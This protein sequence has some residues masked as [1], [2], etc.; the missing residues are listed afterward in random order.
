MRCAFILC[1][2]VA[3]V[4][5]YHDAAFSPYQEYTYE[6][7]SRTLTGFPEQKDQYSGVFSRA[8]LTL[9]QKSETE[10][11]GRLT[12]AEYAPFNGQLI[13]GWAS[14]VDE[15]TL[16]YKQQPF[17]E[18]P[19]AIEYKNGVIR[20]LAFDPCM[21]N[22]HVNQVKGVVSQFQLDLAGENEIKCKYNQMPEYDAHKSIV[23]AYKTMEATV[24]GKC[25]VQYRVSPVP[26]QFA[27][28][29]REWFPIPELKQNH[30]DQHVQIVKTKNFERCDKRIGYHFSLQTMEEN[31]DKPNANQMGDF[32]TR[33]SVSTIYI[34]GQ[35]TNYT[36]QSAATYNKVLVNNNL[37]DDE[38]PMVASY[39]KVTLQDVKPLHGACQGPDNA[40]PV[41]DLV[42]RYNLPS[43]TTNAIRPV[44]E[45]DDD[46]DSSSSSDDSDSSSS[47]SSDDDSSETNQHAKKTQLLREQDKLRER[48]Q[49]RKQQQQ[50]D[51]Q[52]YNKENN[53]DKYQPKYNER[54]PEPTEQ[55]FRRARRSVAGHPHHEQDH[56]YSHKMEEVNYNNKKNADDSDDD[57]SSDDSN[58]SDNSSSSSSSSDDSSSS[59][60]DEDSS[61]SESY[62][63]DSSSSESDSLSESQEFWHPKPNMKQSPEHAYLPFFV[64]YK[65]HSIAAKIDVAKKCIEICQ[66]IAKDAQEPSQLPKHNTLAKFTLAVRLIRIMDFEQIDFVAQK[67]HLAHQNALHQTA[68]DK[69]NQ[70]SLP[71]QHPA[72]D[73]WYAFR[74]ACAEAG[75]GPAVA[76]IFEWV[77]KKVVTHEEAAQLVATLPN[78]VQAPTDKLLHDFFKM[79]TSTYV[80]QQEVLNVTALFALTKIVEQAVVNNQTSY[81]YY[82]VNVYGRLADK[83]SP[84]VHDIAQWLGIQLKYAIVHE[85]SHQV[86][87]YI[88]CLGN[89]G[90]PDILSVFE[91][92]LEGE[93]PCTDFQRTAIVV[94][95]DRLTQNY[96]RL[97]GSVLYKLY[98]N[99]GEAHEVRC[100]AVMQLMRTEPPVHIL[101]AMAEFTHH[102]PSRE[103]RACVKA[104]IESAAELEHAHYQEF[105]AAARAAEPMLTEEEFG[106]SYSAVYLKD[107]ILEKFNLAAL[108]QFTTLGSSDSIYPSGIHAFVEKSFRGYRRETLVYA[109]ASS[110]ERLFDLFD[111]QFEEKEYNTDKYPKDHD[112][113]HYRAQK[114]SA[115]SKKNSY[116]ASGGNPKSTGFADWTFDKVADMLNIQP[117]Q[118][119]PVEAQFLFNLLGSER[120]Y[121]FGNATIEQHLPE[122]IREF[123]GVAKQGY[124]FHYS[125]IYNQDQLTIAFPM[126]SGLIFYHHYYVPTYFSVTG[127]IKAK[128][129]PDVS[130]AG[131]RDEDMFAPIPVPETI[132]ATA[133]LHLVYSVNMQSQTGF[134][135]PQDQQRYIAGHS[136]KMH[137]NL[138]LAINLEIDLENNHLA[139]T[140]RPLFPHK[141]I[142]IAHY[143]SWPYTARK[144]IMDLRPVAE[145]KDIK[146][147][148]VRPTVAL[149]TVFGDKATGVAFRVYGDHQ[150]R[151]PVHQTLWRHILEHRDNFE[152]FVAFPW[153]VHFAPHCN[154]NV[155][156]DAEKSTASAVTFYANWAKQYDAEFGPGG[157]QHSQAAQVRA[158]PRSGYDNMAIPVS[159]NPDSNRR[160]EQYLQAVGAGIKNSK[161][162]MVDC[163]A[164]FH[165]SQ[166]G[167]NFDSSSQVSHYTFTAAVADSSVADKSRA[168]FFLAAVPAKASPMHLCAVAESKL[169]SVAQLNFKHALET[170][171]G[172]DL[173]ADILI[174]MDK[175]DSVNA[176][177]AK[178][179]GKVAQTDFFRKYIRQTPEGQECLYQMEHGDH[180]LPACR[181]VTERA[182]LMQDVKLQ[183]EYNFDHPHVANFSGEAVALARYF[184]AG[185]N[186]DEDYTH[187]GKPGRIQFDYRLSPSGYYGNFSLATPTMKVELTNE[188]LN[189]W[190]RAALAV[191]PDYDLFDRLAITAFHD[192]YNPTCS[193][194]KNKINTF[195]SSVLNY[196][197]GKCWH[198]AYIT[199]E[200]E[201]EYGSNSQQSEETV[202][203]E[204]IAILVRQ[205]N[206]DDDKDVMV[207]LGQEDQHDYVIYMPAKDVQARHVYVDGER[208][209]VSEKE[210]I[211]IFSEDE[212]DQPLARIYCGPV[213]EVTVEIRDGGVVVTTNGMTVTIESP[214]YRDDVLGVCGTNDAER[215]NDRQ[216]PANC[217]HRRNAHFVAAYAL[218]DATCEGQAKPM[219][220]EAAQA[221]C[222]EQELLFTDAVTDVEAGRQHYGHGIKDDSGSSSSSSSSSSESSDSD[223]SDDDDSDS[224]SDSSSADEEQLVVAE[225]NRQHQFEQRKCETKHQTQ[226]V[227]RNG[228]ICFSIRQLPACDS[229]CRPVQKIEKRVPVYCRPASEQQAQLYRQQIRKG[230]NPDLRDKAPT[231]YVNF[232]IPQACVM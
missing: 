84:I 69:Y 141:A 106:A 51:N 97:A 81:E 100:A 42:S 23:G 194:N 172:G 210:A 155:A 95:F 189:P 103:V 160:E 187:E 130:K 127:D 28:T 157:Q 70:E 138:P 186:W 64:G 73:A 112:K 8:H 33:S 232:A 152:E 45:D 17:C 104:A 82:P 228:E 93:R 198:V 134:F 47:S 118:A 46:S 48:Q 213:G 168:L 109:M 87:T 80:H 126:E 62:S 1:T 114:A 20:S 78:S 120:F 181:N 154:L 165:R 37:R 218:D 66:E 79:A 224:S 22:E 162:Y 32:F 111:D 72:T 74:D 10:L 143:S 179:Q 119:Q 225:K 137:M 131:P 200:D 29:H 5:A 88:R 86:L 220:K 132:N 229:P 156:F 139:T 197:F 105:A 178:V 57:S 122:F 30:T 204:D 19:F 221:K 222:F 216:T 34:T 44:N 174:G 27:E 164:V 149:N 107:A 215:E 117:D 124:N 92:Y 16:P 212:A 21:A 99:I 67:L 116:A 24:T 6:V 14:E 54:Y 31:D 184:S 110:V 26:A 98:Q 217:F 96:P 208:K 4:L 128:C 167:A 196:N 12:K 175:C 91:P 129:Q 13:E 9:C 63:S 171:A 153:A 158:S 7:E 68:D 140:F 77:T 227:E 205:P 180:Q 161:S 173:F 101:Q 53:H 214:E 102:D 150:I 159:L 182:A 163:G 145:A 49:Y 113:A 183:I 133:Q 193:I 75:T 203:D 201:E 43:D 226:F 209:P 2:L 142:N 148:H 85:D 231:R 123:A 15:K 83:R 207:V 188:H 202:D 223:D 199:Y 56:K 55:H 58:D 52:E 90:H 219:K 190:L 65:G 147:L 108:A 177:H 94:A 40:L 71:Q 59:S 176:F 38:A 191:H 192:Q 151:T 41:G 50:E 36:I 18:K 135:T 89:L 25:E 195:D 61:A 121:A 146:P 230:N 3:S 76:A 39:V 185:F 206:G 115:K 169:P 11:I 60:S 166:Q 170:V 144:D 35:L 125:K 136:R 211:E